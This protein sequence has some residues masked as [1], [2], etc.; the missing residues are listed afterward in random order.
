MKRVILGLVILLLIGCS[1]N[2][3]EQ[4]NGDE[5]AKITYKVDYTGSLDDYGIF[6][7]IKASGAPEHFFGTSTFSH[8]FTPPSDMEKVKFFVRV[9]DPGELDM[10]IQLNGETVSHKTETIEEDVI[11]KQIQIEYDL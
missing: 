9:T 6:I 11:V 2:D 7:Y 8:E 4:S 10:K 3:D 1:K 5:P